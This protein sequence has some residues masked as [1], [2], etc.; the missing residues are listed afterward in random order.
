MQIVGLDSCDIASMRAQ[1]QPDIVTLDKNLTAAAKRLMNKK[2]KTTDMKNYKKLNSKVFD[3]NTPSM[4][5]E[6]SE[7]SS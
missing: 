1:N 4:F 6:V 3:A 5:D 7:E 2:Q